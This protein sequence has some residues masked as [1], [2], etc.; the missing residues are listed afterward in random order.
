MTP[1]APVLRWTDVYKNEKGKLRVHGRHTSS[2]HECRRYLQHRVRQRLRE[3]S[4]LA[5]LSE[6]LEESISALETTGFGTS[7]I[8]EVASEAPNPHD[9]QIGEVLAQVLLEDTENTRFPWP[10]TWDNRSTTASLPGADLVGFIGADGD[11]RFAFGETKTS[12][13]EDVLNSVIYGSDGLRDQLDRLMRISERR[14]S[15]VAWLLVRS[16]GRPWKAAF[17]RAKTRFAKNPRDIVIIGVLLRCRDYDQSHLELV[18]KHLESLM[19][20]ESVLLVGYYL[21]IE[22]RLWL[23]AIEGTEERP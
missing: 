3:S 20:T 11:E 22:I 14:V 23:D 18:R 9:W 2:T 13:A 7:L 17:D 19:T 21:P 5:Q 12:D 1:S 15:L 8:K 10:P 6:S 4:P 16:S